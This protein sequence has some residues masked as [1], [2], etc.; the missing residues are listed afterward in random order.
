MLLLNTVPVYVIIIYIIFNL[1]FLFGSGSGRCSLGFLLCLV[2][3]PLNYLEGER[4]K[5]RRGHNFQFH[6]VSLS[7]SISGL[8]SLHLNCVDVHKTKAGDLIFNVLDFFSHCF[9]FFF[10]ISY[11]IC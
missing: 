6:L 5:I 10:A 3:S 9:F 4:K 8:K 1:F 11:L 2:S 7:C